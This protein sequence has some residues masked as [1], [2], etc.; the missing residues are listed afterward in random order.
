[1]RFIYSCFGFL[2]FFISLTVFSSSSFFSS[3]DF[4]VQFKSTMSPPSNLICFLQFRTPAPPSKFLPQIL[5]AIR[6]G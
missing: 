6:F 5:H 4:S 1:M 3:S 2:C